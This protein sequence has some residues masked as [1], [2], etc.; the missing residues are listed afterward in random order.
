VKKK[1]TNRKVDDFTSSLRASGAFGVIPYQIAE[2]PDV[3]S[4]NFDVISLLGILFS[5]IL[6]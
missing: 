1:K 2:F 3:I 6:Y 4:S 5:P